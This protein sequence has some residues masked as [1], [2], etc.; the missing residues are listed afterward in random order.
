MNDI[1]GIN[2]AIRGMAFIENVVSASK[3]VFK[4]HPFLLT[5]KELMPEK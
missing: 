3:S 1:P 5:P 2:E 4:W